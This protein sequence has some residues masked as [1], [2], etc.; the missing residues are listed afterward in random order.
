MRGL[1]F[2]W[3]KPSPA[4]IK[5]AGYGF[6][7]RYLSP[8]PSKNLTAAERDAYHAAGIDIG[9]VWEWTARRA[10][11]GHAAG[12]ADGAA[13][14]RQ[15]KALGAPHGMTIFFAVDCPV[16]ASQL[17]E[18]EAYL[19]GAATAL[20][21][22]PWVAGVYGDGAVCHTWGANAGRPTWQSMSTAWPGGVDT[23]ASLRQLYGTVLDGASVDV[24]EPGVPDN[25]GSWRQALAGRA[26]PPA[27]KTTT[28][29]EGHV[30]SL[31]PVFFATDSRGDGYTDV[32][33]VGDKVLSVVFVGDDPSKAGSYA[34]VP[35]SWSYIDLPGG[36]CRLQV[37]GGSPNGRYGA[38]VWVAD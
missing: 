26:A 35:N 17:S 27:T 31:F 29:P 12:A 10:L 25:W 37:T 11:Q 5:A 32:D 8:D 16:G 3:S 4:A 23:S 13:A 1:D 30:R 18:V 7:V 15:A 21:A 22:G 19:R 34:W 20:A 36:R 2:A 9:L 38:R 24:N 28:Y 14:A 6:V 33:A